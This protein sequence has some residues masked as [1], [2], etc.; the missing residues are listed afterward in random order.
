M[1]PTNNLQDRLLTDQCVLQ[2]RRFT[3]ILTWLLAKK[4]VHKVPSMCPTHR[5]L[6]LNHQSLQVVLLILCG[7]S[8]RRQI[9]DK[10][11][12]TSLTTSCLSPPKNTA[13]N[14]TRNKKTPRKMK[15]PT[16]KSNNN[17]A[18]ILLENINLITK[19]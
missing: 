11:Q 13:K 9:R 4:F 5:V 10:K 12:Q 6:K 18:N 17:P 7:T 16:L 1:R 15:K 19:G 14:K 3:E 2:V 8:R